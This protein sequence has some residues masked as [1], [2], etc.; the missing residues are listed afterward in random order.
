MPYV[1]RQIGHLNVTQFVPDEDPTTIDVSMIGITAVGDWAL[2]DEVNYFLCSVDAWTLP[3][4][5]DFHGKFPTIDAAK[6]A[7]PKAEWKED[8][9]YSEGGEG[10]DREIIVYLTMIEDTSRPVIWQR[11][12]FIYLP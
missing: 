12:W 11:R 8:Y 10:V 5:E 6:A 2:V 4:K 1:D 7:A 3:G 9:G